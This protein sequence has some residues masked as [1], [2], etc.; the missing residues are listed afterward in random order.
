MSDQNAWGF[1][2]HTILFL[3]KNSGLWG[4]LELCGVAQGLAFK[5]FLEDLSHVGKEV[6][7]MSQISIGQNKLLIVEENFGL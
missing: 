4:I 1:L 2:K 3:I 7:K 5:L 6:L